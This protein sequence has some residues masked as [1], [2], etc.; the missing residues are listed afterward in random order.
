MLRFRGFHF[1]GK[2]LL[3]A[4]L[5]MAG[6]VALAVLAYFASNWIVAKFLATLEAP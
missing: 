5:S 4:A 6:I 1:S 3:R 2:S